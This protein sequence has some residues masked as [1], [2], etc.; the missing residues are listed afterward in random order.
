[1]YRN[2]KSEIRSQIHLLQ[3]PI[4]LELAKLGYFYM[5]LPILIQLAIVDGS[6]VRFLFSIY[7]ENM[8]QEM[9]PSTN[10][11]QIIFPKTKK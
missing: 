4:E 8:A 6:D 10:R 3:Y 2:P 11:Q 7:V 1:M 9:L 5:F